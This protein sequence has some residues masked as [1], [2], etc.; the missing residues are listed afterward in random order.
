[1]LPIV[2]SVIK[3]L[4]IKLYLYV[5]YIFTTYKKALLV[6]MSIISAIKHVVIKKKHLVN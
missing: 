6:L 1:M 2:A 3:A 5:L 4:L